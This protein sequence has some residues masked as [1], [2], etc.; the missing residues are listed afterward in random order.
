MKLAE[1]TGE[2]AI[3]LL[4][5]IIEPLAEILQDKEIATAVENGSTRIK[6]AQMILKRHKRKVLE[7]MAAIDRED[8]ENYKPNIFVLPMRLV[9]LLSQ[10]EMKELFLSQGQMN[11]GEPSGS[12][13][14]NTEVP[15]EK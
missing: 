9:E 13:T 4:A 6:L 5:D 8:V 2:D 14:A 1:Y 7:V 10:P 3:E 15:E 11:I 12:A